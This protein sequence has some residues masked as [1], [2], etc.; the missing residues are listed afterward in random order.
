MILYMCVNFLLFI[1]KMFILT[2]LH[3]S[4]RFMVTNF[5]VS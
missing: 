5:I 1:Y 2:N 4:G 3:T